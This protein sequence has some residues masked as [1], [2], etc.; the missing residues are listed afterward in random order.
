MRWIDT[1]T[2][3]IREGAP[4]CDRPKFD[5]KTG[6]LTRSDRGKW[7]EDKA[8][9]LVLGVHNGNGNPSNPWCGIGGTVPVIKVGKECRV[10]KWALKYIKEGKVVPRNTDNS[11]HGRLPKGSKAK[12]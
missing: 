1:D 9:N 3:V 11:R 6:Y 4:L 7:H 12:K 5:G 2:K 8:G 10:A